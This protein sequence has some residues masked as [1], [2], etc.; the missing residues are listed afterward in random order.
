[1]EMETTTYIKKTEGVDYR[2]IED[3]ESIQKYTDEIDGMTPIE[4]LG[5]KVYAGIIYVYGKTNITELDDETGTLGFQFKILNR[6]EMEMIDLR[7]DPG[8]TQYIGEILN[9][10]IIDDL[11]KDKDSNV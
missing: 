4:I 1:M 11:D 6:A 9:S 10:I 8:F 7:T 3:P 2:F 5:D